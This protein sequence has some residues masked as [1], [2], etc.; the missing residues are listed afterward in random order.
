MALKMN[1]VK[2]DQLV[3]VNP[4]KGYGMTRLFQMLS[5]SI[6]TPAE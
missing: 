3:N 4:E 6:T 2:T 5:I 1:G